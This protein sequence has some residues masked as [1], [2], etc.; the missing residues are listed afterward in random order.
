VKQ[1]SLKTAVRRSS[2][3][4]DQSIQ[5]DLRQLTPRFSKRT[6]DWLTAGDWLAVG[7]RLKTLR[8][9]FKTP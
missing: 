6:E 1:K 8:P 5:D 3:N 2:S 4:T 9:Q 7:E